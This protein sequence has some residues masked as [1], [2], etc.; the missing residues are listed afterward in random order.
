VVQTLG[1]TAERLRVEILG[2]N[3]HYQIQR[4]IDIYVNPATKDLGAVASGVQRILASDPPGITRVALRG[5]PSSPRRNLPR[6]NAP[7]GFRPSRSSAR[8]D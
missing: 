6:R 2:F 3:D 1:R 5:L 8:L 4:V 7:W